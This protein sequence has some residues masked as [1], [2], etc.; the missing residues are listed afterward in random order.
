MNIDKTPDARTFDAGVLIK[1]Q[2]ASTSNLCTE[3]ELQE[4]AKIAQAAFVEADNG[5]GEVNFDELQKICEKLG[6]ELEK[7]EEEA[8]IKI[9]KDGTGTLDIIEWLTWWLKKVGTSPNPAKQMEVLAKVT[10][11]KFD[12]DSSGSI[13]RAEFKSLVRDLG[14]NFSESEIDEAILMLDQDNSGVIELGEFVNFWCDRASANRRAGGLVAMKLQKLASTALK[15][16]STDIFTAAWSGN[17]EVVGL[18]IEADSRLAF[19]TDSSEFGEGWSALHYA[20]YQGHTDTAVKLLASVG[21]G[22]KQSSLVNIANDLGF[23]PLFYAAQRQHM[24]I[25]KLLLESG[26]DPCLFGCA[27]AQNAP[28][29]FYC[30]ADLAKDFPPLKLALLD[31]PR[32]QKPSAVVVSRLPPAIVSG[33]EGLVTVELPSAVMMKAVSTLPIKYWKVQLN[34]TFTED[35]SRTVKPFTAIERALG[36][37]GVRSTLSARVDRGWLRAVRDVCDGAVESQQ[38]RAK[39]LAARMEEKEDSRKEQKGG[40]G[41]PKADTITDDRGDNCGEDSVAAREVLDTL[42]A[43]KVVVT[44]QLWC[45]TGLGDWSPPSAEIPCEYTAVAAVRKKVSVADAEEDKKDEAVKETS[46]EPEDGGRVGPTGKDRETTRRIAQLKQKGRPASKSKQAVTEAKRDSPSPGRAQRTSKKHDTEFTKSPFSKP[47]EVYADG[48]PQEREDTS[49]AASK[50]ALEPVHTGG[51]GASRSGSR[52]KPSATKKTGSL[53]SPR[54]PKPRP[55]A[56]Q[57]TTGTTGPAREAHG[58]Q[59]GEFSFADMVAA[60]EAAKR[61]AAAAGA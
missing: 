5:D 33:V 7:E 57:P 20:C 16:Y 41:G 3:I 28:E 35:I 44:A 51:E 56:P 49:R 40:E 1:E 24:D 54:S 45:M 27:D 21:G 10:F 30:P 18:F 14:A 2:Y 17:S 60:D 29:H 43:Q 53:K 22:P 31:H 42:S 8:M 39:E 36:P 25:V 11:K 12:A 59:E 50:L 58:V 9:D 19:S 15:T 34:A 61:A 48:T 26:A 6:I 52:K 4:Q 37:P 46:T 55:T 38:A 32:C 13:D 23:T 47:K